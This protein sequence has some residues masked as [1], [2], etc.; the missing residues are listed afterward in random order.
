MKI[1]RETPKNDKINKN[2]YVKSYFFKCNWYKYGKLSVN[3]DMSILI[4][5][6]L[7]NQF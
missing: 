4:I 3:K 6:Y 5:Y 1:F 2:T 7:F